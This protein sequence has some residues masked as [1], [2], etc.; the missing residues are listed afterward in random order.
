MSFE[1]EEMVMRAVKFNELVNDP[2]APLHIHKL[3]YWIAEHELEIE[4]A[5]EPSDIIWENRQV[6]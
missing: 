3:K 2:D 4:K 5:S 1:N 6:T